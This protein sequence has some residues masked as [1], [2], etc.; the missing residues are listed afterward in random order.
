MTKA[1]N[2]NLKALI[3]YYNQGYKGV[4]LEGSSRSGKTFAGVDFQLYLSSVEKQKLIINNVRE[5]YNSF[6]TTLFDDFDKR[7]N[8]IGLYSPFSNKDVQTFNLMGNKVN[9][10]GADKVGKVHGAGSDFFFINEALE[11]ISRQF[12]DQLEQ[13]CR[14]FWW[15][16][17]NPSVSDHWIFELEKRPDVKFVRS[18]F[19]DNPFISKNEKTKILSY[20]PNEINILNG[21]ADDYMW[22]VYGLGLRSSP[23]GL[24]FKN[25]T[26]IDQLPENYESEW[27]G[28]DFGFT[29]DPTAI[30]QVRKQGNNLY[31]K[32][33]IYKPIDNG[34]L[35]SQIVEQIGKQHIYW[36]DTA[37]GEEGMI[38]SLRRYGFSVYP[39]NKYPGS[40]KTGIDIM[41]RFKLHVVRDVDAQKEINN[42]K[43]RKI[44]GISLNEPIDAFNHFWDAFR[45]AVMSNC[46]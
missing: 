27:F 19:I 26:I 10:I 39:V 44:N 43:W 30:V 22:Q 12:F 25:V 38:S 37:D 11:G 41:K 46:I 35:L 7:L 1:I 15:M 36:A 6:K 28:I 31:A 21:T 33:L 5:T 3:T 9:F 17:Y 40:I 13:R 16:D 2:K 23:E 4:V 14:K 29:H 32:L 24:V 20:E 45:Y 34:L 8:Q 18:T 42:Y